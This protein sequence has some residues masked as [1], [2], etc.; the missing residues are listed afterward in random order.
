MNLKNL[1]ATER[2]AFDNIS[3]EAINIV[4]DNAAGVEFVIVN[5]YRDAL[6]ELLEKGETEK[7]IVSAHFFSG[8]QMDDICKENQIEIGSFEQDKMDWVEGDGAW[9]DTER[10]EAW[11]KLMEESMDEEIYTAIINQRRFEKNV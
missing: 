4:R 6:Y 3:S 7:E 11:L 1:N 5:L 9:Q 2:Q 8:C 10:G